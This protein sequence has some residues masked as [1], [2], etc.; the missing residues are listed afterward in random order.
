MRLAGKVAL[1]TGAG[2]SGEGLGNG[3]AIARR[4][5]EH[6][7][8]VVCADLSLDRAHD[9]V[10]LIEEAGGT[11]V[12]AQADVTQAADCQSLVELAV[13]RYGGL[14]ALVNNVG[15]GSQQDLSSA[16]LEGWNASLAVN[17]TSAMLCSQAAAPAL[18]VS[19]GSIVSIGSTVAENYSGPWSMAYAAAKAGLSGLTVSLAGQLGPDRVRANLL[20]VGFIWS[21]MIESASVFM[22]P[23]WREERRLAGLLPEEGTPWDV[24]DAALFLVSDESRW[25]TGQCIVLDAGATAK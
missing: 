24:A 18:R 5:A 16:S 25:I 8:S 4:L 9:V 21:S 11:A 13:T 12:A 2:S 17:L 19:G 22:G 23:E 7:A 1:V 20:V 3:Q 15:V 6:G 10:T 14:H